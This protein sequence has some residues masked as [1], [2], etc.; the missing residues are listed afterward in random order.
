[1]RQLRSMASVLAWGLLVAGLTAVA[2]F[3]LTGG[4]VT[5]VDGPGGYCRATPHVTP[6]LLVVTFLGWLPR[7]G[8][9]TMAK[10]TP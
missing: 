1:M 6:W 7:V 9:P 8:G 2:E 3:A 10:D 4:G 5:C